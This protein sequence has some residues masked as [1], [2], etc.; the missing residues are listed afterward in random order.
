MNRKGTNMRKYRTSPVLKPPAF[1]W[2]FIYDLYYADAFKRVGMI[3]SA[4]KDNSGESVYLPTEYGIKFM[5][6][7]RNDSAKELDEAIERLRRAH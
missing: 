4:G 6:A 1:V 7:H 5:N 2:D 3:R